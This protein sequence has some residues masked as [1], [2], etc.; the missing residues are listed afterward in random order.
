MPD[1]FGTQKEWEEGH[2]KRNQMRKGT[3][4]YTWLGTVNTGSGVVSMCFIKGPE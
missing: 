1:T 3:K 2:S 4:R